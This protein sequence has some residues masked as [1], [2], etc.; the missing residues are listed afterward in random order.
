MVL[1]RIEYGLIKDLIAIEDVVK[2]YDVEDPEFE[3]VFYDVLY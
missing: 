1:P 3:G 2:R